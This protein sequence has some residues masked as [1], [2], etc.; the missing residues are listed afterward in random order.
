MNR[1]VTKLFPAL[2]GG[3]DP[4]VRRYLTA[5]RILKVCGDVRGE[6]VLLRES[7]GQV[8]LGE[9]PLC[10]MENRVGEPHA[11]VLLDFG[12][13][14]AGSLRLIVGSMKSL[15]GTV[16]MLIRTGESVM[17]ALTPLGVSNTTNDHAVRDRVLTVGGL[18]APEINESGFRFAY[19]E[20]V[21]DEAIVKLQGLQG[22]FCYRDLEYLGSFE[23]DDE[24]LNRIWTT[25]AYTV[26]LN[27]Q[28]YLWDGIKRD[29]LVWIGDMHTEVLTVASVFGKLD[30]VERSLDLVRDGTPLNGDKPRWMNGISSYSI[31]WLFLHSDWYRSFGDRG[32]LEQQK[33][34]LCALMRQLCDCVGDD[35]V[36]K[37]AEWRFIDWPN[38]GHPEA[39]H[40]GLQAFLYMALEKGATLLCELGETEQAAECRAR[41]ALLKQHVPDPGSSKQAAALMSLSGLMDADRINRDYL[42]PGGA[43]GYST[44][45]GYYLL[46]AKAKA[47]DFDGALRDLKD[48]WGGMLKMGATT[49]WEDFDL[50]WTENAGRI[51]EIV[52]EGKKDIHGDYGAFCYEKFRH[53]LCHGWSSGPCP[54]LSRYVLGV[55]LVDAHTVRIT[56]HLGHLNEVRGSFPTV[57]GVITVH[58]RKAED[59][60]VKTDVTLPEGITLVP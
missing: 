56:P 59:G 19:L 43:Y 44:F 4:R 34:Y 26:H 20:L 9:T 10:T 21:D 14:F 50:R 31:W 55:E 53:S 28:E 18:S 8:F 45:F 35:G 23:S 17:E 58:H 29:R 32:Y 25:A 60:T 22:V 3:T 41:R 40:A 13:E 16:R 7:S 24:E 2:Q 11:A 5:K 42:E 54:W 12:I 37:M 15:T 57:N 51:D 48:Y 36:E 1:D 27:L 49:F 46:D 39:V 47:G 6:D 38:N 33:D 52:P 30:V